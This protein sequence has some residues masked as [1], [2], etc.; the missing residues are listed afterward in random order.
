[1]L[2]I[3]SACANITKI[4]P[5]NCDKRASTQHCLGSMA[6]NSTSASDSHPPQTPYSTGQINSRFKIFAFRAVRS[7][8]AC[9]VGLKPW[10]A[11]SCPF[12]TINL[13]MSAQLEEIFRAPGAPDQPAKITRYEHPRAYCWLRLYLARFAL[14]FLGYSMLQF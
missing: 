2:H 9:S 4:C 8:R 13:P 3:K 11:G 7:N 5:L 14:E 1:M 12:G 10:A 6:S